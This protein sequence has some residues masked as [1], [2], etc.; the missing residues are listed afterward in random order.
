MTWLY[1]GVAILA[2][3]VGT[4][5]LKATEGF[6]KL[7]PAVVVVLAYGTAFVF[8]S[9]TLRTIPV[10]IAYAIWSGLGVV[11][12]SILGWVVYKQSL[13]APAVIGIGLIMAGVIV[14]NLFS[15]ASA[16]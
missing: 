1:L 3:V 16:Q 4:T 10:G 5:A 8:L 9:L 15:T 11:L 12:I 6:T 14:L 7:G 13:D 2:E